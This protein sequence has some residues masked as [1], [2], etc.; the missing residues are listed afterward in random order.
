MTVAEP[1]RALIVEDSDDDLL[2]LLRELRRAGFVP[3]WVQ[4]QTADDFRAALADDWDVVLSDYQLPQ[5][6]A[7]AAL[8]LLQQNS[9][10]LP[11]I[12]IS[13]TVGEATAV[14]MMRAGAHDYVMKDNLSRLAEAVRREVR[15][16]RSRRDRRAAMTELD[17]TRELLHLAIEGSGIGIWDWQ[18]Q[19]GEIWASDRCAALMGYSSGDLGPARL[20]TWQRFVHPDDWSRKKNALQRHFEGDTPTYDCEFRLRHRQGHWVWVLDRGKV[21]E[22]DDAQRPLRMSGTYT[23][24]TERRLAEAEHRR[25]A[26]QMLFNSLHD[27]LTQ[28]PNRNFLMQRLDLAIQRCKRGSQRQFA[29]LFLDLDHF[30]VINDSLGHLI[31]DEVLVL[32]AQKLRSLIRTSDL[33]A[34]LGGDEFVLLLEDID[35]LHEP[36]RIAERLL[37]ELQVPLPVGGHNVFLN[38]SIGIVMGLGDYHVPSDPLRD[39]DIAMYRAKAQGRSR[40]MVFNES[41]HLQA[42]Q[43]LQLEQE[44][45]DAIDRDQLVL[46][47]QPIFHLKTKEISGFEALVRWQHPDR[48]FVAPDSFIPIAEETGLIVPLDRWVLGQATQ[49]LALWHQHYPHHA[50]LTVSI[51]F[52][53]KDLLRTDLLSDLTRILEQ[54][55]LQGHHLNLEITESTLIE[56]IQ[57]MVT[58]LQQLKH[59]GFTVTIDDFGTGYSSLSYLHQLPVDGL[60]IDRSF[61]M[62]MEANRRNSDIVETIITL[63][64]RLGLAAIAEGIETQAQLH[65]LQHLGCELGQGYWFARPLPAA[66]AETLLLPTPASTVPPH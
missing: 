20:D 10:D 41:M 22:W 11:F 28:L 66:E 6:N 9:C 54:T 3:T 53:V 40:Y 64:N 42:L 51:N 1:L 12:V 17:R 39:A 23:D 24:I 16:A 63:S 33:A 5:F 34:R 30:K 29:V 49:Q 58:V 35:T 8:E 21:V 60:K 13:G 37:Q 45:R 61:V 56:D 26:D 43:R 46:Y 2:L 47:Y 57:S 7:P 50:N 18:V 65:H 25:V 14:T 48:G 36:V 38:A 19:T 31:G 32:V 44:L 55:G 52:S 27:A 59:H 62:A 4:V 15:E